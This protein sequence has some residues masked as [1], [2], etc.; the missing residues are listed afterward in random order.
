[1]VTIGQYGQVMRRG[2]SIFGNIHS[3]ARRQVLYA[4]HPIVAHQD[5]YHPLVLLQEIVHGLLEVFHVD[6]RA[7]EQ[8]EPR[9]EVVATSDVHADVGDVLKSADVGLPQHVL[10]VLLDRVGEPEFA[11]DL[12]L[13]VVEERV[14]TWVDVPEKEIS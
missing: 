2:R 11:P 13:D 12:V 10:G 14:G 9:V 6:G 8:I 3:K 1:M 4:P 7:P 5:E